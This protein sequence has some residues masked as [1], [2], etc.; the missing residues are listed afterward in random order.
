[1]NGESFLKHQPD[2]ASDLPVLEQGLSN[3]FD[4]GPVLLNQGF[5]F[6]FDIAPIGFRDLAR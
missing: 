6:R 1:M 3:R 5:G 4:L 2:I